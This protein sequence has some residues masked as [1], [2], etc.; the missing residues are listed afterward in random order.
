MR[1]VRGSAWFVVFAALAAPASGATPQILAHGATAPVGEAVVR[2]AANG[3]LMVLWSD[4]ERVRASFRLNG[5]PFLA[6][7]VVPGLH[8]L[9]VRRSG[10]RPLITPTGE[11][12]VTWPGDLA[13]TLV[14]HAPRGGPFYA[15]QRAPASSGFGALAF[16]PDGHGAI[17]VR[18]TRGL[19]VALGE[20]DGRWGAPQQLATERVR[21][22]RVAV[23]DDGGV[24]VAWTA[25]GD[26]GPRLRRTPPYPSASPCA[27]PCARPEAASGRTSPLRPR[28][29]TSG[30]HSRWSTPPGAR[31]SSGDT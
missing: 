1:A 31:W 23:G 13:A 15:P 8:S 4:G 20:P 26:C 5:G 9:D 21:N 3:D 12:M 7:H 29:A 11:A 14:A 2:P 28:R 19:S 22:S 24:V 17:L 16:S 27:S 18:P 25:S 6:G 10:V 30:R